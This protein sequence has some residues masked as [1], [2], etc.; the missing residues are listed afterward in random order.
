MKPDEAEREPG[1]PRL[2][3]V[4]G[5][6]GAL[7][8]AVVDEL[9]RQGW[10]GCATGRRA[11]SL[12]RPGWEYDRLDA[13][14]A[15]ATMRFAT[16]RWGDRGLEGLVVTLGG[17]EGSGE[18]LARDAGGLGRMLR[19]N[20]EPVW[21]VLAAADAYLRPGA[22]VALVASWS[23]LV[24]PAP[25]GQAA[26]RASKAVVVS[27]CESLAEEWA[28]RRIRVNALA[29]TTLD[30]EDNRNAIPDSSRD[31]WIPVPDAARVVAFLL[32]DAARAVT[33]AVLPIRT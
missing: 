29:P 12:T 9:A 4:V 19:A 22:S 16:D 20:A 14:D 10:E 31:G 28:D 13:L 32:S 7:G 17:F 23:T 30:T 15:S 27:L 18:G 24:R 33:G 6:S 1:V 2:V 25:R 11:G 8:R 21:N 26:Y 3:W 5:G